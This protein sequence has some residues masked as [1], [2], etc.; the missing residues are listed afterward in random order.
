MSSLS[1]GEISRKIDAT[2]RGDKNLFVKGIRDSK[3]CDSEYICFVKDKKF[4]SS[5]SRTCG[6][7]ILDDSLASSIDFDTNLLIHSNPYLAYANLTEI[8]VKKYDDDNEGIESEIGQNVNIGK[9]SSIGKNCKISDNVVIKDNVSIYPGTNIGSNVVIHSGS[10]LGSDGFGF[11]PTVDGW[12]KIYHLGGL[13]IED[14]CEIGANCTIDRGALGNTVLHQNVKLDNGVHLAHNVT[15][16]ENTAIAAQT[17]IAGS[18]SVGKNCR[19]AG[20][21]GITDHLE[22]GDNVTLLAK[23]LVTTSILK[24]GTYSSFYPTQEHKKALKLFAKIKNEK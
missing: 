22:I 15:I 20:H 7:V 6:A 8:F 16:G 19:I 4:L 11:V 1:L 21:V 12:Q 2:L 9:H 24:S 3:S 23:S 17:A 18:V 5:L 14:H 13:I 10:V